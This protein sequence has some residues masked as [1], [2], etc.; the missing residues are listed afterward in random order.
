MTTPVGSKQP[1]KR[2]CKAVLRDLGNIMPVGWAVQVEVKFWPFMLGLLREPQ[3]DGLA[4]EMSIAGFVEEW[5]GDCEAS[6]RGEV[7]VRGA[8]AKRVMKFYR[9]SPPPVPGSRGCRE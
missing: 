3:A 2:Q 5:L 6:E 7:S 8:Y 9:A 4:V 1:T